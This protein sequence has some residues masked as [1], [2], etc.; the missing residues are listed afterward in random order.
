MTDV[1]NAL[2]EVQ[3]NQ[4]VV[5]SLDIAKHFSKNHR[6]V[7]R[8][9]RVEIGYAQNCAD[10]SASE[11]FYETTYIHPQNGQE[12]PMFLINRDGFMLLAMGFNGEKA[13]MWK[14]KY[15][16]AFN[17]MEE[18]IKT[19]LAPSYQIADEIK[20]AERW[21]E[22]ARER[23]Q[24]AETN[25]V[26]IAE[27]ED[28]TKQLEEEKE[29]KKIVYDKGD[30]YTYSDAYR[31][32]SENVGRMGRNKFIDVLVE[33][34]IISESRIPYAR[35]LN[36]GYFVIKKNIISVSKNKTF[37]SY[38]GLVTP[39]GLDWLINYFKKRII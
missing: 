12:Y 23:K 13:S 32:L 15:I 30:N 25:Q 6:D 36:Q 1:S 18:Q 26:L 9:I 39:K 14:R 22:E 29:F 37:E 3:N 27:N 8:D 19:L 17:Q 20:R 4:V 38:Q 31:V 33:K 7:L 16:Q 11:M 21:L 34:K 28:L 35:Y 24:L 5:S 10:P 2:V